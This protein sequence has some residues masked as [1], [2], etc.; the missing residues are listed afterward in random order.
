[1]LRLEDQFLDK[2]NFFI[3]FKKISFYIKQLNEWYDPLVLAEYEATLPKRIADIIDLI[4]KDQYT[5]KP[6]EPLPFPKKS[7]ST[8][9]KRIR[10]YYNISLDDQLIWMAI[11]NVIGK[12]VE[13]QMPDWSYGNRLY[14]PVWFEKNTHDERIIFKKGSLKNTSKYVYRKWGQSWPL[15]KRH[16]ALTIKVLA[17]TTHFKTTDIHDEK[18]LSVYEQAAATKFESAKYLKKDYWKKG[19]YSKLSWVSLDF[20]K[21][22]PTINSFKIIENIT[23]CLTK[24][25]GSRRDDVNLI[26]KLIDKMLTFP[27]NT[28]GWNQQDLRDSNL[29]DLPNV[30]NYRGIPTGL[31]V[32]GFLANVAVLDLDKAVDEF[33]N[34]NKNI[35]VFKYVDDHIVLAQSREALLTFLNF[36][37]NNI[38]KLNAS[39]KF[40]PSK[41]EPANFLSY[42]ENNGFAYTNEEDVSYELDVEFPTPLMTNTLKKVSHINNIDFNLLEKEDIDNIEIDLKHLL[43]AEFPKTEIRPDTKMSFASSKLCRLA[44]EIKPDFSIIDP[45]YENNKDAVENLYKKLKE[46]QKRIP[47]DK[48]EEQEFKNKLKDKA[49]RHFIANTLALEI[50]K[51]RKKQEGIFNLLLKALKENPDKVKLWKKCIEFCFQTGY[52]GINEILNTIGKCSIHERSFTYLISYCFTNIQVNLEK[53]FFLLNDDQSL[54]WK[55]HCSYEFIRNSIDINT[56]SFSSLSGKYPF[57]KQARENLNTSKK[58]VLEQLPEIFK[59]STQTEFLNI[60]NVIRSRKA[61]KNKI[62]STNQIWYYL[63]NY[64]WRLKDAFF[65]QTVNKVDLSDPLSWSI[66]SLFPHLIPYKKI[67][68]IIDNIPAKGNKLLHP[69]SEMSNLISSN[70]F[71]YDMLKSLK[72]KSNT[73]SYLKCVKHYPSIHKILTR[74]DTKYISMEQWLDKLLFESRDLNWIDPRLTEWSLIEIIKQI[75]SSLLKVNRQV[76][77]NIFSAVSKSNYKYVHPSN[78]LIPVEW[79]TQHH[80]NWA[81]W[82][83]NC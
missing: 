22:F 71:T 32:G 67:T 10:P 46:G 20:E 47:K 38:S 57:S 27:L 14:R 44:L 15:Y 77:K 25:N 6:I 76:N 81:E 33:V 52:P 75:S 5:P 11:V 24:E 61:L 1:M 58:F 48:K 72:E 51:V 65:S 43:L 30:Q 45:S 7:S 34:K 68:E 80:L 23:A 37:N 49:G 16:I 18:E 26:L 17:K 13:D 21:F 60:K 8:G 83:K 36:Y 35:A 28:K 63:S 39:L 3:A 66:L 56:K 79:G 2:E 29:F 78:Y 53:S 73:R 19:Q 12:Y 64:N 82:E 69:Y 70:G 4:K 50:S 42:D 31:V 55:T 40:Q 59:L 41:I 62:Y 9:E 54:F 74:A